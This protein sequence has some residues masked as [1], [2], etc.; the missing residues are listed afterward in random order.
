MRYLSDGSP[1][2]TRA[3]GSRVFASLV[4]DA[5]PDIARRLHVRK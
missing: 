2:V 5:V 4:M 1:S 3:P